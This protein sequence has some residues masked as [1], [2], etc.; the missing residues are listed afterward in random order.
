MGNA[1]TC[2][3]IVSEDVF[4]FKLPV[5]RDRPAA[6]LQRLGNPN[7][8]TECPDPS[9]MDHRW[10]ARNNAE[11]FC[12][13]ENN[14]DRVFLCDGSAFF[15]QGNNF[16]E[17]SEDTTVQCLGDDDNSCVVTKIDVALDGSDD[18]AEV[19]PSIGSLPGPR[20][21]SDGVLYTVITDVINTT[22]FCNNTEEV[23][24]CNG[25]ITT[26]SDLN[27]PDGFPA[28]VSLNVTT[29]P[30]FGVFL[31]EEGT[32][33][34][35]TLDFTVKTSS[36]LPG[37]GGKGHSSVS[38]HSGKGKPKGRSSSSSESSDETEDVVP[39]IRGRIGALHDSG[40]TPPMDSK[41]AGRFDDI[42]SCLDGDNDG[43]I[44]AEEAKDRLRVCF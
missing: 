19:C 8:W 1:C 31:V 9:Y 25:E 22:E 43:N 33:I 11:L 5:G 28:D 2:S 21:T 13:L 15:L 30:V 44:G 35:E 27:I 40:R 29:G 10:C 24:F 3:K 17:I 4:D 7:N 38:G 42:L 34:P 23:V 16:F 26:I 12:A 14:P 18:C 6:Q 39:G 20:F 37:Q 36:Q 41:M 32:A